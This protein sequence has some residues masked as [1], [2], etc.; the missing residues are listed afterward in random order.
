MVRYQDGFDPYI[1]L[2]YYTSSYD[3]VS[4]NRAQYPYLLLKLFGWLPKTS[5][6]K[7]CFPNSLQLTVVVTVAVT[8][9]VAANRIP[10]TET[11]S[12]S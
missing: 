8:I 12:P 4:Y 9:D 7:T 2:T 1:T 10:S 11:R 6:T 3:G 5:T